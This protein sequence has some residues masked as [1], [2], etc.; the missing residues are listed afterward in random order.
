MQPRMSDVEIRLFECLLRCSDRYLEFGSGGST[1]LASDLVHTSVT[2]I[3]SC[4]EWIEK[5]RRDCEHKKTRLAPEMI[6]IDIG[7]TG[8]WG[9][10]MDVRRREKWPNYHRQ[11]WT[12]PATLGAD[13]YLV[14]GRFRVACFM[15]IILHCEL[16][17][18]IM[19]HDYTSRTHY[20]VISKVAREIANAGELAVFQPLDGHIRSR[21]FDILRQYEL[22]PA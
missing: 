5:V 4:P 20:H 18:S 10:P 12:V 14:D 19:I 1:C 13:L 9:M 15:Q 22:D 2:S 11:P 8:G 3:D 7:P 6:H 16:R 17:S 21:A